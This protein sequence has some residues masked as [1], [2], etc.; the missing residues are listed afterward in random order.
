[1]EHLGTQNRATEP[2]PIQE[3]SRRRQIILAELCKEFHPQVETRSDKR[4]NLEHT[5]GTLWR[6]TT[7]CSGGFW[8][9]QLGIERPANRPAQAG[10]DRR[11]VGGNP[12]V[13]RAACYFPRFGM[14][15]PTM[16]CPIPAVPFRPNG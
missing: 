12:A 5:L 1:M 14:P 13:G 4:P 7:S 16:I 6:Q 2:A 11:R 3:H 15:C 8:P 9:A 10:Q